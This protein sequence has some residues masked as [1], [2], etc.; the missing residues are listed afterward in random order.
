M[1][2]RRRGYALWPV[3]ALPGLSGCLFLPETTNTTFNVAPRRGTWCSR[4]KYANCVVEK[5][6]V[7]VEK[8]RKARS[9]Y[10]LVRLHRR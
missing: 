6:M 8:F 1:G 5:T 3:M 4:G 2:L 9:S 10:S 7:I